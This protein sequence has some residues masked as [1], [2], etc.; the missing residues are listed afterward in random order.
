M[1]VSSSQDWDSDSQS[2]PR[3]TGFFHGAGINQNRLKSKRTYTYI[4][5]MEWHKVWVSECRFQSVFTADPREILSKTETEE[6]AVYSDRERR[7]GMESSFGW[8]A[9]VRLW[10]FPAVDGSARRPVTFDR[11][12]LRVDTTGQ[13]N[14]QTKSSSESESEYY[15]P[16][17]IIF[18]RMIRPLL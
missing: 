3:Y 5:R 16:S 6:A 4:I 15:I 12:R 2:R 13:P 11:E 9:S 18:S 14:V 7:C 1:L 17:S 8:T 10:I